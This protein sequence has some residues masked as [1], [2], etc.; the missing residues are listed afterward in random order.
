MQTACRLAETLQSRKQEEEEIK[1]RRFLERQR[2]EEAEAIASDPRTTA[3]MDLVGCV[4]GSTPTSL[5]M[6]HRMLGI[7][8]VPCVHQPIACLTPPTRAPYCVHSV[9]SVIPRFGP[10]RLPQS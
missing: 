6:H 5:R 3:I 2:V 1:Q 7:V 4:S 10:T 8:C 9:H